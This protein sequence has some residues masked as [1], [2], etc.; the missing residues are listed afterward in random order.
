M[1][2]SAAHA[3]SSRARE[4]QGVRPAMVHL[5]D[6]GMIAAFAAAFLLLYRYRSIP[7]VARLPKQAF[8]GAG[9]VFAGQFLALLGVPAVALYFTPIEWT[10][11]ILWIDGAIY[12]LRGKSLLRTYPAEFAWLA[13]CSIPLWLLFE[14]YNL[15]LANWIYVGLPENWLARQ[16][17]YGWA[18]ATIWPGIFETAMLLRALDWNA[19]PPASPQETAVPR[20]V[21][22]L[23]A[24]V[25]FAIGAL[26]LTIPGLWRV[27]VWRGVAR[28][29]FPSGTGQSLD[30]AAIALARPAPRR[31]FPSARAALGGDAVRPLVGV[32]ELACGGALVL[33]RSDPAGLETVRHAL[34]RLPGLPGLCRRVLRDVLLPGPCY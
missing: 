27:P 22:P 13:F 26:L 10:G 8:L 9:I 5:N 3:G 17:G 1:N 25:S 18:F 11:Y 6:L 23:A 32:L 20:A 14:A 19:P 24:K 16:I 12:S 28:I 15:R 33:Y 21:N 29:H 31:L 2:F 4:R 7:R 30:R 34:A